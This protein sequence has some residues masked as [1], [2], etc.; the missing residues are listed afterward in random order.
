LTAIRIMLA[1]DFG[2]WRQIVRSILEAVPGFRVIAEAS[3]GQEAVQKAE[4]L[5]PDIVLLD[6]GMPLLNGIEAAKKIKQAC[7]K[8][9][10][11]FLTQQN[12]IEIRNVALATG[13]EAYLSKSRAANELLPA[14]KTALLNGPEVYEP[15]SRPSCAH[16]GARRAVTQPSQDDSPTSFW[17]RFP[18]TITA[19]AIVMVAWTYHHLAESVVVDL[20]TANSH[21]VE[22]SAPRASLKPAPEIRRLDTPSS[23]RVQQSKGPLSGFKRVQVGPDEVDY[24]AE[25]VTMRVFTPRPVRAHRRHVSRQVNIGE[26]AT[27]RYF[28]YEP[29]PPAPAGF[30]SAI[31]P[32][33]ERTLPDAK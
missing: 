11:I 27:V 18:I 24:V 17:E 20:G 19:L 2:P 6:I 13:A 28:A 5:L 4:G 14:I 31:G 1:D 9:K 30:V 10:V 23:G 16:A 32:S 12:D 29:A 21:G 26:D 7:P 8:S 15:I 33:A 22:Q 25:D 3:D